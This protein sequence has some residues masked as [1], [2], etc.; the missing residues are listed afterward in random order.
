MGRAYSTHKEDTIFYPKAA[1]FSPCA[2]AHWCDVKGPQVYRGSLGE[3][4]KE[5]RKNLGIKK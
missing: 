5:A 3:G 1:I 2:A 4:R